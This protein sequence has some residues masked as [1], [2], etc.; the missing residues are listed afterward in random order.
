MDGGGGGIA[1]VPGVGWEKVAGVGV[2]QS[3]NE[4]LRQT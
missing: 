2:G 3:W 1:L 4:L